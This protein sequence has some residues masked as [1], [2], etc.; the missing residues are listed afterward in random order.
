MQ[1]KTTIEPHEVDMAPT[2]VRNP[3]NRIV[4]L[5]QRWR[6]LSRLFVNEGLTVCV[7]NAYSQ[8][9]VTRTAN[10]IVSHLT[11]LFQTH[12]FI[13]L[14]ENPSTKGCFQVPLESSDYDSGNFW[15]RNSS[16]SSF[17]NPQQEGAFCCQALAEQ[18]LLRNYAVYSLWNPKFLLQKSF[19]ATLTLCTDLH[20]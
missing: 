4:H 10:I 7:T 18:H 17:R 13:L 16:N 1:N 2:D 15:L 9:H 12:N 5:T 8:M 6:V 3:D 14:P 11:S 20:D 19:M